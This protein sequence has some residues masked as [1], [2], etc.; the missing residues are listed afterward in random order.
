MSDKPPLQTCPCN[1]LMEHWC[2]AATLTAENERL[3][4]IAEGRAPEAM[5][6][7]RELS[8]RVAVLEEAV[9]TA[10]REI[11]YGRYVVAQDVLRATFRAARYLD[12]APGGE[13]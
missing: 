9:N 8:D 12:V 5:K 10:I 7:L 1:P 3:K 4:V 13:R 2:H 6:L 11:S